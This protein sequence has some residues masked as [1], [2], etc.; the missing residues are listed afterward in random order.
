MLSSFTKTGIVLTLFSLLISGCGSTQTLR[1]PV[2]VNSRIG[3]ISNFRKAALFQRAGT[4]TADNASFYRRIPGLHIN[5]LITTTVAND[6]YRS[7]KYRIIPIYHR[8][9]TELLNARVSKNG[10][11][12]PQYQAYISRL[13]HNKR[14]HVFVLVTPGDIDFGD[15]QYMGAIWWV[16][17]YGLFNRAFIFMETN[18]IFAAYK[19]YVVDA[20]TYKVLGKAKGNIQIR[21]HGVRT[22]WH[23][24]YAGVRTSTLK[25]I[26]TTLRKHLPPAL[27]HSVHK[28]GLP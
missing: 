28:T 12:T 10:V 27:T 5:P 25:L 20:K 22:A 21:V 26:N 2:T 18:T 19:V 6:L 23:K 13:I 15:G 3:V 7:R 8:T 16:T 11:L 17:G 9:A 4:T 1:H 24:G 14:L